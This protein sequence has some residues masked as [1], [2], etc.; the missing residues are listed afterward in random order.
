MP[1]CASSKVYFSVNLPMYIWG[2]FCF[3][4]CSYITNK[5][6]LKTIVYVF[7]YIMPQWYDDTTSP[8]NQKE[9]MSVIQLNIQLTLMFCSLKCFPL[10]TPLQ[11]FDIMDPQ[12]LFWI[13]IVTGLVYKYIGT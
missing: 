8:N 7:L 13:N 11:V 9:F 5:A 1:L 4:P 6:I 2:R 3:F 10:L 12:Y